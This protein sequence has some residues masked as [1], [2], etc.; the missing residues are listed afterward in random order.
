MWE[1]LPVAGS[2]HAVTSVVAP[3]V[4]PSTVKSSS[5]T[6]VVLLHV[7]MRRQ[8][9]EPYRERQKD[10]VG[11][12]TCAGFLVPLGLP[13]KVGLKASDI[14][15]EDVSLGLVILSP[16]HD[17]TTPMGVQRECL[18]HHSAQRAAAGP[19]NTQGA[20]RDSFGRNVPVREGF[21][22]WSTNSPRLP[23]GVDH[24]PISAPGTSE[25]CQADWQVGITWGNAPG[26]AK[27][28]DG[29]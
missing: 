24:A 22:P 15:A 20:M 3:H 27:T 25:R 29:A 16:P 26:H 11:K 8:A 17:T 14:K 10:M 4:A 23:A 7:S 28:I 6:P 21:Q 12:S 9:A 5:V 13:T 2:S 18:A 19:W 1:C